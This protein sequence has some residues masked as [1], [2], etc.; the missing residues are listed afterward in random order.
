M[1]HSLRCVNPFC[2]LK[3]I[4]SRVTIP[5]ALIYGGVVRNALFFL[6]LTL[7]LFWTGVYHTTLG[8]VLLFPYFLVV[9]WYGLFRG[10]R[11]VVSLLDSIY[12]GVVLFV[13]G[14]SFALP[15]PLFITGIVLTVLSI[16]VYAGESRERD[17]APTFALFALFMIFLRLVAHIDI[18]LLLPYGLVVFVTAASMVDDWNR[19]HRPFMDR[20][21]RKYQ[22]E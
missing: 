9:L 5:Q 4:R 1:C 8:R 14:R 16:L 7:F 19:K 21:E 15:R 17:I 22:E 3:N 13:G 6:S 2:Y 12:I 10:G 11:G 18:S 20:R